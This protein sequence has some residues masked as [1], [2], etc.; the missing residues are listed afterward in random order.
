[1]VQVGSGGSCLDK[2]LFRQVLFGR[3]SVQVAVALTVRSSVRELFR[4]EAVQ[5]QDTLPNGCSGSGRS[6]YTRRFSG[7]V[8]KRLFKQKVPLD[9]K[10]LRGELLTQDSNDNSS[11]LIFTGAV[12]TE[13]K[14]VNTTA[15]H[16]EK[17]VQ[18]LFR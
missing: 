3:E 5:A 16:A 7:T 9:K 10:L 11:I 14:T 1:M 8:A 6:C 18:E 15:V 2:W 13:K 12:P 4:Q 17:F